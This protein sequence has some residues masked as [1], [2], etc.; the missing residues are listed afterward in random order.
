[1]MR[2]IREPEAYR[3]EMYAY[4][5]SGKAVGFVPTMG[6]LHA[7]HRS[8]LEKAVAENDIV[9]ASIFINPTQF[10][11]SDDLISYPK[12]WEKDLAMLEAAGTAVLFAP[13]GG[14]IYP[15]GYRYTVT[16]RGLSAR[17]CGAHRKGHFD[18]VLTVVMKLLQLT[19]SC[20][21][22]FGEKDWQQLLLV[23][24][25]CRAFFLDA[26]IVPCPTV[27]EPSGL[28]MSSRNSRLSAGEREKA[29]GLYRI[30]NSGGS[31]AEKRAGLESIGFEVEY[32]EEH[33]DEDFGRRLLAAVYLD[34]VR[35]IDNIAV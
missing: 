1:M 6:A 22:Y 21:A 35:L 7:G 12:S 28:A 5:S 8:L 9:A 29:A 3:K 16:E 27:R 30:L 26:A 25:M 13:E 34:G 10:D 20:R 4:R 11:D 2:I 32:L 15:D 17:F 18:G 23:R 31:L 24:D 14:D 19:G 33:A